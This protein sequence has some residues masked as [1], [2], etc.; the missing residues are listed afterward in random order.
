VGDQSFNDH[1][2]RVCGDRGVSEFFGLLG[3]DG[4]EEVEVSATSILSILSKL[5]NTVTVKSII[6]PLSVDGKKRDVVRQNS[7][8]SAEVTIYDEIR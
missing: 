5:M 1:L 3:M 8:L 4:D 7:R 2:R 6:N